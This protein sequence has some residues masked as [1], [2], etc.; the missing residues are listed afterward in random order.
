M[1]LL[2]RNLNIP[3][4]RALSRRKCCPEMVRSEV[5]LLHPYL[6]RICSQSWLPLPC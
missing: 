5:C 4:Q 3:I 2:G 6:F 1:H